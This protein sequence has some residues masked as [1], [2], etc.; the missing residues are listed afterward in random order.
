MIERTV[1]L[2]AEPQEVWKALTDSDELSRWFGRPV[3]LEPRPGGR[4]RVGDGPAVRRGLIEDIEACRRLSIRWLP[5][6]VPGAPRTR[7]VFVLH[8]LR[9]GTELTIVESPLWLEDVEWRDRLVS[10]S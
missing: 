4:V 1:F 3:E 9:G 2:P 10:A 8:A 6:A 7:V 5:G